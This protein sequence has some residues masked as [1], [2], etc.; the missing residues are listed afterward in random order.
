VDEFRRNRRGY[1]AALGETPS[2]AG[3]VAD[4]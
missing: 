3:P 4:G 2:A 1:L